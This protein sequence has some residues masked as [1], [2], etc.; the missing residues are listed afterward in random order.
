MR[1]ELQVLKKELAQGYKT[2]EDLLKTDINSLTDHEIYRLIRHETPGIKNEV[3]LTNEQ[4][5]KMSD[6]DLMKMLK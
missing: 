2:I 4:L 5:Q 1:K 6:E 3:E